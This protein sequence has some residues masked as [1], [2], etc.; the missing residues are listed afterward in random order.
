VPS[1]ASAHGHSGTIAVDYRTRVFPFTAA[2]RRLLAARIYESDRAVRL[3]VA[4]GHTA[5]ILGYLGEP[6]ARVTPGGVEVNASAPTAGGAELVTRL[7]RHAVGWQRLSSGRSVTWHDNRV[8]ALPG[9]IDRAHWMIP[10]IVDG[11]RTSLE[12]ELW[13]VHSPAWWPWLL[14][15]V[16]FVLVSLLLFF[17]RRSAVPLAA[18]ALGIGAAAGTMTSGT[19]FAVDP[20]ASSGEWLQVGG[21]LAFVLVGVAVITRGSPVTRGIAGGALGLLGIWVGL[22][23]YPVLVHGVV[24]STFPPTVARVLVVL[25]V[26]SAAAA[27][28]LGLVVYRDIPDGVQ[29][30]TDD[31]PLW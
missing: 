12:G 27:L 24:L 23:T 9:G 21:E 2:L 22:A 14:I 26:W 6:F 17:W 15:G 31:E 19:G 8:R 3:T 18:A 11:R 16:P 30:P 4:P 28:A 20:N 29:E 5:I 1:N 10:L 13:R 25:T 7:S